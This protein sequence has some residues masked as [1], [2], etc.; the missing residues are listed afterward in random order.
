MG[1]S[2]P[3]EIVFVTGGDHPHAYGDKVKSL[4]SYADT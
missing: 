3:D 2:I 1:T 4:L